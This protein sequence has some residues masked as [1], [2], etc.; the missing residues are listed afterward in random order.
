MVAYGA[1][2]AACAA[3]LA[4]E[5]G[6]LGKGWVWREVDG[7]AHMSYLHREWE[8]AADDDWGVPEAYAADSPCAPASH[9]LTVEQ[10]VCWSPIWEVPVLYMDARWGMYL[11]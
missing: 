6:P 5:R 2:R 8:V 4:G 7:A 1:F 10:S 3:F 9:A 11:G